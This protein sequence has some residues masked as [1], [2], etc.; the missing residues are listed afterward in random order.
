M[1]PQLVKAK[2]QSG[3]SHGYGKIDG[4]DKRGGAPSIDP[5]SVRAIVKGTLTELRGRLRKTQRGHIGTTSKERPVDRQI[6]YPAMAPS[7]A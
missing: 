6:P 4:S 5:P 1:Q 2:M 3:L 7:N